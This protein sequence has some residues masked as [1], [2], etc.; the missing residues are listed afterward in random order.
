PPNGELQPLKDEKKVEGN[1]QRGA[2]IKKRSFEYKGP[3]N[4][5]QQPL[6]DEK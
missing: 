3:P 5:E 1:Q 2:K 4:G 6:K